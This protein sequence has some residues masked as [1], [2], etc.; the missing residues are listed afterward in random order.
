ML[1]DRVL[2]SMLWD[3][4]LCPWGAGQSAEGLPTNHD[5]PQRSVRGLR[6]KTPDTNIVTQPQPG[7]RLDRALCINDSSTAP[8]EKCQNSD[9]GRPWCSCETPSDRHISDQVEQRL[10]AELWREGEGR[11]GPCKMFSG[12]APSCTSHDP[13]CSSLLSCPWLW[14]ISTS[15]LTTSLA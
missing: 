11:R 7:A 9:Q 12:S 5:S 6:G 15:V 3:I 4:G 2:L 1:Q 13:S 14:F 8:T 10:G